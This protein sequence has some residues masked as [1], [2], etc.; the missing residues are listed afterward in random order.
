[1][2]LGLH[3]AEQMFRLGINKS[4][5]VLVLYSE[6]A[7]ATN[8]QAINVDGGTIQHKRIF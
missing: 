2:P 7:W 8:G 4:D 6:Y 1:L 5:T 3:G